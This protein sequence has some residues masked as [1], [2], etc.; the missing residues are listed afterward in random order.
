[1]PLRPLC[2]DKYFSRKDA[3]A[4]SAA[5]F[6][7]VFF[8][9][10]NTLTQKFSREGAKNGLRNAVA[11]CA[12]AALR[13]S[14]S[15]TGAFPSEGSSGASKAKSVKLNIQSTSAGLTSDCFPVYKITGFTGW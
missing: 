5:A 2:E 9:P 14:S 15:F 7:R 4:Q 8:A 3:K 10:L 6:L 12:F 13:E 11:L 1:M